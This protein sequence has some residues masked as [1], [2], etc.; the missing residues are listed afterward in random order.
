TRV[1]PASKRGYYGLAYLLVERIVARQGLQHL[2]D[3]CLSA[4]EQGLDA[5]PRPWLL[6]AADLEDNPES[7]RQAALEGMGADELRELM[8]MHPDFVRDAVVDHLRDKSLADLD[9][10]KIH[11]TLRESHTTLKLDQDPE[12]VAQVRAALGR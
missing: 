6:A 12:F 5:V 8:R 3:L 4:K 2:L 10:V 11:L 9:Q 7:W 1:T